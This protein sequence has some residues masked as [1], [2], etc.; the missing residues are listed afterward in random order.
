MHRG[1]GGD[2]VHR[3]ADARCRRQD[4]PQQSARLVLERRQHEPVRLARVGGENARP[5]GV[6]EDGHAS[7]TG[8]RLI[9]EQR[10][11]VEQLFERVGA[12]DARLPE[13]IADQRVARRQRSRVR[14]CRSRARLRAPRFHDHD[15]LPLSDAAGDLAELFRIAE[16]LQVQQDHIRVRIL[17]PVLNEVIAGDVGFVADG[18][19]R[20]EADAQLPGVV[21]D[22]QAEGSALAGHADVAGGREDARERAVHHRRGVG[23]DHAHAVRADHAHARRA[24]LLEKPLL[25]GASF[26]A[27]LAVSGRDHNHCADAFGHAV[28]DDLFDQARRHGD[29]GQVDVVLDRGDGR[30]AADAVHDVR[31][32][33]D[34]VEL[35]GESGRAQVVEDL[36]A[37]LTGTSAGAD[38]RDRPRLE[39]RLHRGVR[40]LLRALGG[41][42][43]ERNGRRDGERNV[44]RAAIAAALH[45]ESGAG[46]H[47]EHPLVLGEHLGLEALDVV[48]TRDCGQ[49]LEQVRADAAALL[50]VRDRERHLGHFRLPPRR[51]VMR[52]CHDLA[53]DLAHDAE[54]VDVVDVDRRVVEG[55]VDRSGIEEP[56]VQ[57]LRRQTGEE[58]PHRLVIRWTHGTD[59]QGAA[60][61]QDDV[62]FEVRGIRRGGGD[63]H[64]V[65]PGPVRS[66]TFSVFPVSSR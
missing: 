11:G 65:T 6:R 25:A 56:R 35:A 12:D 46:E 57:R 61:A 20:R 48:G 7:P 5:A 21:E 2:H 13:E 43:V 10:R 32:R 23:V 55:L 18:D 52:D 54:V 24:D 44:D 45:V 22:G 47:V 36:V 14:R 26:L 62:R 29:D 31:A 9:R 39:H 30:D 50:V 3:I 19:E 51:E 38:H 15:R 1:C 28:V 41:E 16:A 59:A 17:G 8:Q 58:S 27:E 4:G 60:G 66:T 42:V 49:L 63:G 37:E 53:A 33:I 34:R 40:A 64:G